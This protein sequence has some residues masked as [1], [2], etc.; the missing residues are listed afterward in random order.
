M[1]EYPNNETR[2]YFVKI[3]GMIGFNVTAM[4]KI[5]ATLVY[6]PGVSNTV[7]VEI[8]ITNIGMD[9]VTVSWTVMSLAM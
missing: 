7:V 4:G 6:R 9:R 5:E 1:A 3:N 8:R 2:L